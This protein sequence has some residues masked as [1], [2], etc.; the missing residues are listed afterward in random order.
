[1]SKTATDYPFSYEERSF[2]NAIRTSVPHLTHYGFLLDM[3]RYI[4]LSNS[5]FLPPTRKI[6]VVTT[7]IAF[8]YTATITVP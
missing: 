2:R 8:S 4:Q 7:T 5:Q 1:M 6:S 3:L